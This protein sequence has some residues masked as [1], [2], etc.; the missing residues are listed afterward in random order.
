LDTVT[1]QRKKGFNNDRAQ[2]PLIDLPLAKVTAPVLLVHADT[3]SDVPFEY[4]TYAA[5]HVANSDLLE[6]KD[7]THISVWTGPDE[8]MARDRIVAHLH[9]T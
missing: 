7:G 3:D 5:D 4:S 2:F 1:G 9:Q 6:I 8:V